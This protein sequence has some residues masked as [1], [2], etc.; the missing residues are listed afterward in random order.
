MT[1][2]QTPPPI[3]MTLTLTVKALRLAREKRDLRDILEVIDDK[4]LEIRRLY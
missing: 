1:L 4:R 2:S 3:S